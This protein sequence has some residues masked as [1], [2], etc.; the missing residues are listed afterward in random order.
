[1]T[2]DAQPLTGWLLAQTDRDDAVGDLARDAHTEHAP[3]RDRNTWRHYL[4]SA[5][6]M[7]GRTPS[8]GPRLV[9]V[10]GRERSVRI[11]SIV[12]CGRLAERHCRKA[13][14]PIPIEQLVRMLEA[15]DVLTDRAQAS[16]R[17]A[18]TIGR[19]EA[20]TDDDGRACVRLPA[21]RGAVA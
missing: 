21:A 14:A 1:M 15:H 19:L 17:L 16:I 7:P 9:R 3:H 6:R 2:T 8:T 11:L 20:V 5:W 4:E 12:A 18:V 13:R 10:E